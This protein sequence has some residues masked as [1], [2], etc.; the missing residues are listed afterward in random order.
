MEQNIVEDLVIPEVPKVIPNQEMYVYVPVATYESKGIANF[1]SVSLTISNGTVSVKESFVDSKIVN[2]IVQSTGQNLELAIDNSTFVLTA[3]LKNGRGEV[4][5]EVQT[6]DLPLE[7]VVVNGSYDNESKT[8]VLILQNGNNVS[9]PISSLID[10]LA[11][12][13]EISDIANNAAE[14]KAE[15]VAK[16]TVEETIGVYV[17]N[18]ASSLEF[19]VDN[20]TFVLTATLKNAK[21]EILGTAQTVDLPLESVVVDGSYD[22]ESKKL[23]LTLQNGNKVNIPVS[24][25]INGLASIEYL[26]ANA[27]LLKGG[28]PIAEGTDLNTLTTPGSYYFNADNQINT[29]LN[30][31]ITSAF[32]MKVFYS[33]GGVI[34]YIKQEIKQYDTNSYLTRHSEDSGSTWSAWETYVTSDEVVFNSGNQPVYG[35]KTFSDGIKSNKTPAENNDVVRL[36]DLNNAISQAITTALNTQV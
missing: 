4:L 2:K 27:S 23:V 6:V 36:T 1:D 26:E 21:G 13:N 19:A 20:S 16:A 11:S 7:N 5:G 34:P 25:L 22:N 9:I 8:L 14:K 17:D 32:T 33:T 28:T 24:D 30:C 31:P 18:A 15:S 35:I 3:K 12:K 10:G 29:L